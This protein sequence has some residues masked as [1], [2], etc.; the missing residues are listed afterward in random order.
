MGMTSKAGVR[1]GVKNLT[2]L[3]TEVKECRRGQVLGRGGGVGVAAVA[4][5]PP[6]ADSGSLS[7]DPQ[8]TP[9]YP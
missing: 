1:R 7:L 5:A 2:R 6:R 9:H 4:S 8:G 3:R